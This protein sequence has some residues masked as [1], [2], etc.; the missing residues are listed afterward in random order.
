MALCMEEMKKGK[1]NRGK[2]HQK[3]IR[4][5]LTLTHILGIHRT[6]NVKRST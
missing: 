4:M 3:W 5:P 1:G 6:N 2:L